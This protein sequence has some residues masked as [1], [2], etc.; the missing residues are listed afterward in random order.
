MKHAIVIGRW[1]P[2]HRGHAA[3]LRRVHEETGCALLVLVRGTD[4]DDWSAEIRAK[5]VEAYLE[6]SGLPGQAL[7]IPDIEGVYYGRGVGYEVAEID[8]GADIHQVSAT[9][10]RRRRESGDGTWRDLVAPGVAEI[11]DEEARHDA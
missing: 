6:A 8:L 1:S 4:Y 3:L 9:E 2:L 5:M 7:A 10:I 11:I